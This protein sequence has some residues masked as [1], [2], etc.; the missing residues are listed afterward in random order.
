M[1]SG[2]LAIFAL[3]ATAAFGQEVSAA[4]GVPLSAH[5]E[6]VF[7]DAEH[8]ARPLVSVRGR[9]VFVLQ[10][11]H[12][13][14]QQSGD[15]KLCRLLFF[16]G[17]VRDA[18]ADRI[19]AI[20]PYLA[21]ARKDRRTK[22]RD[23]VTIRYVATLFEAMGVDRLVT[24]DVHNP[25]AFDNAF[26]RPAINLEA[27]KPFARHFAARLAG[28]AICVMSPDI[29][30]VKRADRFRE[31]LEA[32]TGRPVA[33]AFMEK[34]RSGGVVSGEKVVG[35]VEG[36]AVVIFDDLIS[37]GTTMRRAA[38]AC[39][40]LGARRVY[41]A[42]SHGLF[43]GDASAVVT[44]PLFDEIAVTSSIPPFRLSQE[45]RERLAVVDIAALFAEA[46]RRLHSD[47]SIVELLE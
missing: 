15:E 46:I 31:A 27:R 18:G 7:E 25:A 3:D 42:A 28:E 47:G 14:A 43:T 40:S 34:Y 35:E 5:E 16:L 26:R 13:D 29:G 33:T 20:V 45:A 39:R 38:K 22:P 4:L 36:K 17:A 19:T 6:R 21:Y 12:G 41:A 32:E 11:L 1:E 9:D 24:L 30:G 23:P 37:T 10:S 8:K 44:D 2:D